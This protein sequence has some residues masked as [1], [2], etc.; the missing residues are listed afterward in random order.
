MITEKIQAVNPL[1]AEPLPVEINEIPIDPEMM[2]S[3]AKG[4]YKKGIEKRQRKLL[5]KIGFLQP[6]LEADE[7]VI[8]VTTGCSPMTMLEQYLGGWIIFSLKRSLF[9]FTDRRVFHV[10]TKP[11]FT[12]RRSIAHFLYSDCKSI[13]I[14]GRSLV[15]KYHQGKAEKFYCIRGSELGKLKHLFKNTPM[16]EP[17]AQTSRR[18]HL[19]PECSA[20]LQPQVYVCSGCGQQFK[21]RKK[22]QKLSILVPGGGYFYT[23]HWGLGIGDAF[24]EVF[25]ALQ[26]LVCAGLALTGQLEPLAGAFLFAAV[27]ILEKLVTIYQTNHFIDEYIPVK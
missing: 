19:C 2:F 22:A 3:N 27:L 24:V 23:G 20:V 11:N 5:A 9:I 25:L 14:S 7:Q 15:V 21:N 16:P 17:E 4:I 8:L 13:R 6:F 10:P 26:F 12:Y 1:S 18:L